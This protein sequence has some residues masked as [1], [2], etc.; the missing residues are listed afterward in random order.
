MSAEMDALV[1]G[2]TNQL[3]ALESTLAGLRE[4]RG[5][6]T[7]ED[8]SV[9][10]EVDGDGALTGLRLAESVT[11]RPPAEV[12]RLVVWACREAA[13]RATAQRAEIL[14]GLNESLTPGNV[15]GD[16]DSARSDH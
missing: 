5:R 16:P 4:V 9:S 1:N 3:E 6:F 11:S 2:V 12:A 8:R 10:A 15:G 7:S 14:A 13:A